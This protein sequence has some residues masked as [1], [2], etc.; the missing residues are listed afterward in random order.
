[1]HKYETSVSDTFE[2]ELFH[3]GENY[4]SYEY[5]G[6][7]RVILGGE[8]GVVFRV[9][10]PNAI[11]VS[12]VG[13][14]NNWDK[15][16]HPMQK[17]SQGVWECFIPQDMPEYSAYKYCIET[18]SEEDIYKSDPYGFHFE[19]RP[20]NSTL[21]YDVTCFSWHDGE[22]FKAKASKDQYSQPINIYEL[23][24]GSWRKYEDGSV[25]SY[26]KMAEELIPYIKEMGYTH[27]ELMPLTEYPLDSSLGYST[28]GYFAPTSRYGKPKDFMEFIDECHKAGIGVIMDWVPTRFPKDSF[29]LALFDGTPCYEYEDKNKAMHERWGAY[30]FDYGKNEV[31]SFLISSAMFWFDYYHLDG[32]RINALESILYL[33]FDRRDDEWTPNK[34]GGKENLEAIAFLKKLN[35]T[36]FLHFPNIMMIT[37]ESTSW[38]TV[39]RP[40]YCDG[41]GFNYKW[42]IGLLNDLSRYMSLDPL[43]RPFNHNNLT[44]SFSYAFSENFIIPISHQD[45]LTDKSSIINKMPGSYDQKFAGLR[46]MIAYTMAHPGKKLS[47]MGTEFG[48]FK[49][50]NYSKELDWMLLE[51]PSHKQLH[52]FFKDINRFYLE[53]KPLWEVDFNWDGFKP[54]ADDDY[55]QSVICFRRIDTDGEEII[56]V[57]NFQPNLRQNY[58]IGV[59][60]YGVYKEVFSTD[61]KEYG[62][63]G[64]RNAAVINAEDEPYHGLEQS[65]SIT[66]PPMSVVYFKCVK[67]KMKPYRPKSK[68]T[69]ATN[70][71]ISSVKT[72][73]NTKSKRKASTLLK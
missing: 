36:V 18:E 61:S 62:G 50:W 58:R 17:I 16:K 64:I 13:V 31:L 26:S 47:F 8:S 6:A 54:I 65:I 63:N 71:D 14:F 44:F 67:V 30:V 34:D 22:W 41:L 57:C 66:L 73:S 20:N 15:A 10:A 53:N 52:T 38:A 49:E 24:L 32:L 29:G 28:T 59:P 51:Y 68:K 69:A 23:H 45:V 43:Y 3:R 42:N 37:E 27:I 1:M 25:F 46:T 19:T 72:K 39:T 12:V 33:D 7:H 11:K 35:E 5:M 55:T 2:L 48:Q 70:T 60:Y 9:W 4:K 56:A 21:F 40:T